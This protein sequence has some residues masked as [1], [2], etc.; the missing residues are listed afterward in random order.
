[1]S[2][3]IGILSSSYK[4]AA[5]SGGSL[6]LDLYPTAA[7]AFS[8]RKLRTAYSGS[9]IRVA[10]SASGNPFADIGFVG[11]VLDT[12]ALLAFIGSNTG[13][14]ITWYDQSGNGNH[15]TQ[16]VFADA[17]IIVNAGTLVTDGGKV[18]I[19]GNKFLL[20][21]SAI[22]PNSSYAGFSVMSRAT[23]TDFNISFSANGIPII[24]LVISTSNIFNYNNVTEIRYGIS[25]GYTGRHLYSTL[26]ILNVQT[27][28][29]NGTLQTVTTSPTVGTGN[30]SRLLGRLSTD[31][32]QG[33]TQEHIL[34][35]TN[36]S[37]N[38][39]GINNNINTYY[40][41]Y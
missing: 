22:V 19:T 32:F 29:F 12:A 33:K 23:S 41:I 2:L 30:F 38:N 15:A 10:S 31:T 20:L 25:G 21:N 35:N 8:F 3:N 1:M 37:S 39:T 4:A 9:C 14:V 17:C 13:R 11:D 34:Y 18:A 28:Y 16:S 6:L 40:S 7:A 27:A 24:S 36:Q 26:N 5:P